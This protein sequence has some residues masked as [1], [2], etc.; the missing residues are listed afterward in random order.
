MYGVEGCPGP[1]PHHRLLTKAAP[2]HFLP[3]PLLHQVN[4]N[5]RQLSL[6]KEL[7]ATF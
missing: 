4:A 5:N 3:H 2:P 7:K 6:S 1:P